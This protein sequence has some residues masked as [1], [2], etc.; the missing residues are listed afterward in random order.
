MPRLVGFDAA[1]SMMLDGKPRAVE[2]TEV[3]GFVDEI[4]A[5]DLGAAALTFARSIA[6]VDPAPRRT[7]N[8]P[9][10]DAVPETFERHEEAARKRRG[11]PAPE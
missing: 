7:A 3:Q 10:P 5:K 11:E 6:N 8:R 9:L 4:V 1:L 2:S